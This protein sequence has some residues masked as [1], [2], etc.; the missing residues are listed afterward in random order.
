VLKSSHKER[1]FSLIEVI[2]AVGILSAGIITVMQALTYA[3]R[4]SGVSSD[5]LGAL[6]FAGD[7]LQELEFQEKAGPSS[8]WAK[9]ESAEEGK[10]KWSYAI[11]EV[12][13]LK[14]SKLSLV[15]SWSSGGR[16]DALGFVT[17]LR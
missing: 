12:P 1:A 16:K 14:L 11:E 5:Y 2:I 4:V 6:F 10:F 7:K 15:V 9:Q 13:G 8:G 3:A 17:Y